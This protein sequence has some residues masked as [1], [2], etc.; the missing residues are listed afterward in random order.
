MNRIRNTVA[1]VQAVFERHKTFISISATVLSS[2]AA[3][4][5]YTA[6]VSHQRSLE[7]KIHTLSTEIEQ[8]RGGEHNQ[9][10]PGLFSLLSKEVVA[11][12]AATAGIGY[13]IGRRHGRKSAVRSVQFSVDKKAAELEKRKFP[14][15]FDF[16]KLTKRTPAVVHAEIDV[17]DEERVPAEPVPRRFRNKVLE[18]T[19]GEEVRDFSQQLEKYVHDQSVRKSA[20]ESIIGTPPESAP[21]DGDGLGKPATKFSM[22][23]GEE[24]IDTGQLDLSK[25]KDTSAISQGDSGAPVEEA[26]PSSAP[27]ANNLNS[28][29]AKRAGGARPVEDGFAGTASSMNDF[30][31]KVRLWIR[32]SSDARARAE[33]EAY[34]EASDEREVQSLNLG[35]SRTLKGPSVDGED[36]VADWKLDEKFVT[37]LRQSQQEFRRVQLAHEGTPDV[38]HRPMKSFAESEDP[39]PEN[40]TMFVDPKTRKVWK[41]ALGRDTTSTS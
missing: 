8:V 13:L 38:D 21:V 9:K 10:P 34:A 28:S 2:L 26:A 17:C 29:H 27:F 1:D 32:K 19:E 31:N 5:G 39:A 12:S 35:M 7:E 14:Y 36:P 16:G 24:M 37:N 23:P 11:V 33:A 18:S 30:G 15:F 40:V 41:S 20:V 6:R 4:A 3:W 25:I 22:S